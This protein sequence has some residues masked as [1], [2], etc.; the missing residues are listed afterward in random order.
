MI[1]HL[2]SYNVVSFR[3]CAQNIINFS[4]MKKSYFLLKKT[5]TTPHN[6]HQ[7]SGIMSVSFVQYVRI[8]NV[9]KHEIIVDPGVESM[10][11]HFSFPHF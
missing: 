11:F 6:S 9:V 1:L 2:I 3:Y 4:H 7:A 5:T 10:D 8:I